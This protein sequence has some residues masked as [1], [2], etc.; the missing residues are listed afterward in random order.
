VNAFD[1]GYRTVLRLGG[2][3]N[4]ERILAAFP[5]GVWCVMPSGLDFYDCLKCISDILANY[6]TCV[7]C[8]RD[9]PYEKEPTDYDSSKNHYCVDCGERLEA[10][11]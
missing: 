2:D 6:W 5:F 3:R 7:F 11:L 8:Q 9:F 4:S 1:F 10:I